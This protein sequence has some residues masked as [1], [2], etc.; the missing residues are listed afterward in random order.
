MG[1]IAPVAIAA[2]RNRSVRAGGSPPMAHDLALELGTTP[3]NRRA[4]R[5]AV[6]GASR[7]FAGWVLSSELVH[8]RHAVNRTPA[9]RA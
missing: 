4:G 2:Y 5:G 8:M 7:R 1:A 9:L 3:L 6:G